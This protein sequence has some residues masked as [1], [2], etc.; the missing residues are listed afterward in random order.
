MSSGNLYPWWD[1]SMFSSR[2]NHF[3]YGASEMVFSSQKNVP[4]RY[5]RPCV[6]LRNW[7]E[8]HKWNGRNQSVVTTKPDND[9]IREFNDWE[10][11]IGPDWLILRLLSISHRLLRQPPSCGIHRGIL[12]T[13]CQHQALATAAWMISYQKLVQRAWQRV[14]LSF[15]S[16]TTT[17]EEQ[18][19]PAQNQMK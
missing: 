1:C 13:V 8:G 18:I 4:K 10:N 9:T 17:L 12:C 14:L 11:L 19:H 6:L 5:G 2:P 7:S 16:S 15:L 3:N